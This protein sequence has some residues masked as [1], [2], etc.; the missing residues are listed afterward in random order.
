MTPPSCLNSKQVFSQVEGP[1]KK[2]H[3]P[4]AIQCGIYV[5]W[6]A[7][8]LLIFLYF[9]NKKKQKIYFYFHEKIA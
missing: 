1:K 2:K 8:N 4:G 5:P 9:L 3:R 6:G 7:L